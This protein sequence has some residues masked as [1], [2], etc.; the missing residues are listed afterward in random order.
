[1]KNKDEIKND[2]IVLR[3]LLN[4]IERYWE[5]KQCL[6]QMREQGNPHWKQ[7]EWIGFYGEFVVRNRIRDNAHIREQGDRFGN[8]SFDLK[9]AINWDIKTHPNTASAAILN[10]CE[11]TEQ[12]IAKYG[13][14]GL[15]IICVD[16]DYDETGDF[17]EWHDRLKGGHSDY[18]KQRVARGAPSRRRKVAA[19]VTNINYIILDETKLKQLSIKQDGWRNSNGS[20]RRPKYSITH[21]Q[22]IEMSE[23]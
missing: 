16:C 9:G 17:K 22:I 20:P 13:Y 15:L 7:M 8:V 18:E 2:V 12:S 10:D 21:R 23:E 4:N 14:Q 3:N 5:G 11:A 6:V 1:M 19:N